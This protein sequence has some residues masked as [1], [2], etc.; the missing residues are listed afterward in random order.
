MRNIL[1]IL[2]VAVIGFAFAGCSIPFMSK[3]EPKEKPKK[4]AEEQIT[5][6]YIGYAP[7]DKESKAV[8]SATEQG[9]PEGAELKVLKYEA[10]EN[11]KAIVRVETLK[12]GQ[13]VTEQEQSLMLIHNVRNGYMILNGDKTN[14][15]SVNTDMIKQGDKEMRN[16][17]RF[18]PVEYAEVSLFE[19][20][21][22]SENRI[23]LNDKRAIMLGFEREPI[24][25]LNGNVVPSSKGEAVNIN[26]IYSNK[27]KILGK[28][29]QK[30]TAV[31]I[32]FTFDELIPQMPYF[33]REGKTIKYA[34]GMYDKAEVELQVLSEDENVVNGDVAWRTVGKAEEFP[35]NPTGELAVNGSAKD[36]KIT[37]NLGGKKATFT[38]PKEE[39]ADFKAELNGISEE[40]TSAKNGMVLKIFESVDKDWAKLL[41][42]EVTLDSLA[43][44][45]A[46]ADEAYKNRELA[47]TS[48]ITVYALVLKVK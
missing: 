3:D 7:M 30:L 20:P 43:K 4:Q 22:N 9:F 46:T 18:K 16:F 23:D 41:E 2:M 26:D 38:I 27:G 34:S 21:A 28:I 6:P 35:L 40:Y 24:H 10:G 33:T 1:A 45:G 36:G 19:N 29:D 17:I 48:G 14:G 42:N 37:V 12:D 39:G 47:D 11:N 32:E 44:G 8:L 25:T 15:I 5:A 13:W 31:T